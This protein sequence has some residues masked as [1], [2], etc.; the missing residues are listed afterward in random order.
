MFEKIN[1]L[2]FKNPSVDLPFKDEINLF[3]CNGFKDKVE[4]SPLKELSKYEFK[5]RLNPTEN[6][7]QELLHQFVSSLCKIPVDVKEEVHFLVQIC[8]LGIK[9]KK[10]KQA[11]TKC[12]ICKFWYYEPKLSFK[13]Q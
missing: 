6:Q 12:G 8:Q 5:K 2:D 9:V 10:E 3:E 1:N 11:A 13:E 4:D 7:D